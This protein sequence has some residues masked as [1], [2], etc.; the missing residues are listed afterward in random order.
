MDTTGHGL[1]TRGGDVMQAA[2]WPRRLVKI[3]E[4]GGA[5]YVVC[6]DDGTLTARDARVWSEPWTGRWFIDG[7]DLAL[8]TATFDLRLSIPTLEAIET[9]ATDQRRPSALLILPVVPPPT[10]PAG[11][12]EDTALVKFLGLNQVVA[13]RL[14]PSGELREFDLVGGAIGVLDGTWTL[15]ADGLTLT[16]CGGTWTQE[17]S[18]G[19]GF[20]VGRER[21]GSDSVEVPAVLVEMPGVPEPVVHS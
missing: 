21:W 2:G 4:S 11:V 8:T 12:R 15:D 9:D 3:H 18:D 5:V 14:Y 13:G 20:F 6:N 7:Q 1:T 10:V 17:L 16:E 19:H